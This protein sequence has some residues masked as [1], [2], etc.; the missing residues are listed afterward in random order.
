M[1]DGGPIF[2]AQVVALSPS[3]EPIASALTDQQGNF[4][5]DG[6]PAGTDRLYAEP[7]DGPGD[8]E[9]ISGVWRNAEGTSF[10]T[11][12]AHGR[13]TAGGRGGGDGS[14]LA[15]AHGAMQA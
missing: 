2:A 12:F 9:K 4:S 1:G 14:L 10:P 13:A 8:A 15:A 7:P 6:V 3:G 11:P 5:I